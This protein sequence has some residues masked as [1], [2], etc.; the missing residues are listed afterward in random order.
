MSG[1]DQAA[2]KSGR[3]LQNIPG[4]APVHEAHGPRPQLASGLRLPVSHCVRAATMWTHLVIF[5]RPGSGEADGA[6]GFGR[7]GAAEG[8]G[9]RRQRQAGRSRQRGE[10]AGRMTR[11]R[12][13]GWA[14][15][16]A[17]AYMQCS[18]SSAALGAR[19]SASSSAR[20]LDLG[21]HNNGTTSVQEEMHVK[22]LNVPG[23]SAAKFGVRAT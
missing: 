8:S 12:D 1:N 5:L 14:S 3:V 11:V 13:R 20:A 2:L 7:P 23:H 18:A 19:G 21:G 16:A 17:D 4:T 9:Q 22:M 15:S 10:G 6:G